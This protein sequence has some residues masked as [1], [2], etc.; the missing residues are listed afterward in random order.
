MTRAHRALCLR[1]ASCSWP[2]PDALTLALDPKYATEQDLAANV[3]RDFSG[4]GN[5]VSLVGVTH[6][7]REGG[8]M[9][10]AGSSRSYAYAASL[11]NDTLST[12][13]WTG[14]PG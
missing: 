2:R 4:L 5:H 11:A 12:Q 13:G 10:F 8:V 7:S 9:Q 3:W 6:S 14:E 1:S